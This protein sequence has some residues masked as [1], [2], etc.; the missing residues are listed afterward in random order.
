M[1]L[2][3]IDTAQGSLLRRRLTFWL[4]IIIIIIIII[5]LVDFWLRLANH[6]VESVDLVLICLTN[7]GLY[8]T[9]ISGCVEWLFIQRDN[10]RTNEIYLRKFFEG[11]TKRGDIV[12]AKFTHKTLI[13]W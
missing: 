3:L 5:F 10:N 13:T 4:I 2:G 9:N 7:K 12:V 11:E 6:W 1:D 8:R